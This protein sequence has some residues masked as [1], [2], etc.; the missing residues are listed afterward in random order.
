M[1]EEEKMRKK[2]ASVW[3]FILVFMLC[4]SISAMCFAEGEKA[5]EGAEKAAVAELPGEGGTGAGLEIWVDTGGPIGCS[6]GTVIY[7]GAKA[8]GNDLGCEIEFVYSDWSAE[9]MVENFKKAL[10]A[11]PD[12]IAIMGHPGDGT[13]EPFIDEAVEKGIVVTC[14]DTELPEMM[15]K[16]QSYGFGY[17]GTE[18]YAQGRMLSEE[19][20]RRFGLGRGDKAFVWGLK[21]KAVRGMRTVGIIEALEDAGVKVDYLDISSEVDKDTALGTPLLTG[22]L[23]SNPDCDLV[24]TDHGGLTAQLENYF[25]AAG[26]GPD[27]IYGAGFSLSP[28]TASGIRNG[29]VD[30]VSEGQPFMQGYF[31]VVQI[32]MA[33]KYGFTGFYIDTGGGFVHKGNID[34]VGPLAEK[35]IR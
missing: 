4:F 16:Y 13:Y 21:G 10:A 3:Y 27:E 26:V 8:A 5:Q 2:N 1:N 31:A 30:L 35:G 28:A 15:K 14:M 20:V 11:N 32:V 9:K 34:V 12:G 29:Y 25:T 18:N 23:A 22:Y 7:N 17:A 33:K 6:Y 19:A 24:V